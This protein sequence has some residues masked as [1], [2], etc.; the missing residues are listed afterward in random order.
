MKRIKDFAATFTVSATLN[1]YAAEVYYLREDN[2]EAAPTALKDLAS[3]IELQADLVAVP[4]GATLEVDVLKPDSDPATAGNWR[5]ARQAYTTTGLKTPVALS[6]R[7][8]VRV[9]MKSGGTAGD[10]EADLAWLVGG[11]EE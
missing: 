10:G 1:E 6:G 8:G 11:E 2:P 7:R 4:A 5:T 3:V 9:R